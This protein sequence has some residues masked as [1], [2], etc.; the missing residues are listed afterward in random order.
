MESLAL[1]CFSVLLCLI[2]VGS[3]ALQSIWLLEHNVVGYFLLFYLFLALA[4]GVF[5]SQTE[6]QSFVMLDPT[7]KIFNRGNSLVFAPFALIRG[8]AK[9]H[10]F[11]YIFQT[12]GSVEIG[13]T[14]LQIFKQSF[15][16]IFPFSIIRTLFENCMESEND[17]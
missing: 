15:I 14:F 5:W 17:F 13:K 11:V 9:E 1:G 8:R 7:M 2:L 10:G 6:Q 3:G 4:P 12:M 16:L